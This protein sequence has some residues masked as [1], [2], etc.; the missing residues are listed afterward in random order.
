HTSLSPDRKVV[1]IVGDDP[2]GLLIDANSGKTLHSMKGHRDYSG[3]VWLCCGCE[4]KL[5]L[6]V[7][8]KK[9]AVGCEL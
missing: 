1:V 3:C 5:L 8:V 6:A 4:K 2:D 9:A 7:A